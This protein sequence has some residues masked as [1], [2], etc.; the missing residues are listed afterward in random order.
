MRALA[1]A[2][3]LLAGCLRQTEF[4]CELDTDCGAAGRCAQSHCSVVDP[5]CAGTGLRFDSSAG[6]LAN[7]CVP[8]DDPLGDAGV[9][10]PPGDG[11]PDVGCPSDYAELAGGN[12]GHVYKVS[13]NDDFDG[14]QETCAATAPGRAYLAI[15][16]DADEL[17]ALA[18]LVA[19]KLWVGIRLAGGNFVNVLGAPQAFLPFDPDPPNTNG[20]RTCVEATSATAITTERCNTKLP[21][22]CECEP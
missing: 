17:A 1:I 2:A 16:D 15:P 7:T 4:R 19:P 11:P 8:G 12:P 9:D 14:S 10:A 21:A 13:G 22:I 6:S 3:V 18:T 5:A 20:G